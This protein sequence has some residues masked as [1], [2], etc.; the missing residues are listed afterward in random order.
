MHAGY[1][2]SIT[3]D[4][5]GCILFLVDTSGS[6]ADPFEGDGRRIDFLTDAVNRTLMEIVA[7]CRRQD[8]TRHYF[9]VGVLSYSGT[10][11]R[12]GLNG[13]LAGREI[14]S[15]TDLASHPLRVEQRKRKVA[16]GA[17]GVVEVD[18]SFPVWF[19]PRP[20]G[21]TAMC[22]ALR[23]AA[24]LVHSWCLS[25]PAS[26]PP[27]V[28]HITD[29]EATDGEPSK[30]TEAAY[31]ITETSTYDGFSLLLNLH[32]AGAGTP[33]RFPIEEGSLPQHPF[34]RAIFRGSSLLPPPLLERGFRLG[35]GIQPGSR[36]YV[37]NGRMDDVIAFLDIGTK[38]AT[39]AVLNP[40][41]D[42]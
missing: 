6:M 27:I 32:I 11:V 2:A 18:T 14:V 30:V 8:G 13:A 4:S 35:V 42:R 12:S 25:H 19:E 34:A 9:D 20:E 33:I 41:G 1:Q 21:G 5:P 7:A 10:T 36:G 15:S 40:A 24:V 31:K 28:L 22:G 16:D 39:N 38:A 17:G 23:S 37:F 3:R 29:G 26:F